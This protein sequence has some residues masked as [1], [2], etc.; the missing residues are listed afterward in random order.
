MLVEIVA[1]H[2]RSPLLFARSPT[3][4]G[5]VDDGAKVGCLAGLGGGGG[6]EVGIGPARVAWSA[7]KL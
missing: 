1:R 4:I 7:S 6:G 2:L 5:S 3:T